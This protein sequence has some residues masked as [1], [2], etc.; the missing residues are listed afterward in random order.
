MKVY[1][2][3]KYIPE[4]IS[5][6]IPE[7]KLIELLNNVRNFSIEFYNIRKENKRLKDI[8]LCYRKRYCYYCGNKIKINKSGKRNRINFYCEKCQIKY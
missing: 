3:Q 5:K 2:D 4:S 7:E 8:L 6:N 1:L